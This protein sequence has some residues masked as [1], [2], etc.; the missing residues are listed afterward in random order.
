MSRYHAHAWG[1]WWCFVNGWVPAER[2]SH[3]MH[4][5]AA[6]IVQEIQPGVVLY[7]VSA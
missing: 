7:E 4:L 6:S 2:L 5:G 1:F 3:P